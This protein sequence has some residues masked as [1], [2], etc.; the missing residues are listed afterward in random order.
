MKRLGQVVFAMFIGAVLGCA[1]F[2]HNT[3]KPVGFVTSD[4][5]VRQ[6][7]TTYSFDNRK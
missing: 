2:V 3:E 1:Q 6:A 5:C 7:C 4:H